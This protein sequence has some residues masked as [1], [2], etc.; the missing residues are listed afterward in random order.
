MDAALNRDDPSAFISAVPT[1]GNFLRPKVRADSIPLP[2]GDGASYETIIV[3]SEF[4]PGQ[5]LTSLADL[6]S[7]CVNMEHSWMYDLEIAII[8]PNGS[9]AQLVEQRREVNEVYLGAPYQLDDANTPFPPGKG[10]G[11]EYCWS[12]TAPNEN[13]PDYVDRYDPDTLPSGYY[14]PSGDLSPLL[15]CPLNGEWTIRVTDKW[16]FD[17]GWIFGWGLEL[18]PDLYPNLET[19]TPELVSGRWVEA[20]GGLAVTD[21]TILA[22]PESAGEGY[23]RLQLSDAFGC[24]HE[25]EVRLPVL[26]PMDP[27]CRDCALDL[28]ALPD[29]LVC[30]A[31]EV[32]YRLEDPDLPFN[33]VIAFESHPKAFVSGG[34]FTDTLQL[35]HV[36]PQTTS[37][38]PQELVEVCLDLEVRE[39]A[40]IVLH[41]GHSDAGARMTLAD[42]SAVPVG[43]VRDQICFRIN[44]TQPPVNGM[45]LSGTY[46]AIDGWNLLGNTLSEGPWVIDLE[47]STG[48]VLLHN[49]SLRWQNENTAHF[50]W[51]GP[52]LSCSDCPDPTLMY[53]RDT[54]YQVVVSDDYFCRDST[55]VNVRRIGEI[56]EVENLSCMLSGADAQTISWI[57]VGGINNYE[58]ST[59]GGATWAPTNGSDHHRIAGLVPGDIL[60]VQIRGVITG[61]DCGALVADYSC[62]FEGCQL[63]AT[64]NRVVPPLCNGEYN[65][66]ISIKVDQSNGPLLFRLVNDDIVQRDS[67]FAGLAASAYTFEVVDSF[68]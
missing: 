65:G 17:N 14:Q 47:C 22:R 44:A 4:L 28:P 31:T 2:D 26:P 53:D 3:F 13:W 10:E 5:T 25:T 11:M 55:S 67:L 38:V 40:D 9:E 64:P 66:S 41:L 7:I 35:N 15:G 23:Y 8:C 61:L 45:P 34:S 52:G 12:I 30:D 60:D 46:Q 58:I 51:S 68:G 42:V 20:S 6:E 43:A 57:P 32:Q 63:T 18:N 36:F 62:V 48:A 19:Y 56:P 37:A 21:T 33:D 50:S 59:D 49:W 1:E 29:T 39:A 54:S 16:E 24:V 27:E